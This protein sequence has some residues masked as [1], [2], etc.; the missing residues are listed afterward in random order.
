MIETCIYAIIYFMNVKTFSLGLMQT[1]CYL[2][3]EGKTCVVIDPGVPRKQLR[4]VCDYI[5]QNSLSLA[6]I[7]LTHGHFDHILGVNA[8]CEDFDCAVYVHAADA[9]M[10][11]D[12][13]RNLSGRTLP[14]PYR[15]EQSPSLLRDGQV[16]TFGDIELTVLHT[17][18]H[19]P[20]SCCLLAGDALFC[21]DTLF[22]GSVGRTDL[23]G[24]DMNTLRESLQKLRNLCGQRPLTAYPGHGPATALPDEFYTNPYYQ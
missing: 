1:G 19:T 5:G 18:G 10:L 8:L 6:A 12:P 20:G 3:W 9:G 24:G 4:P 13:E 15:V 22:A 14:N 16:L 7:L 2:L 23:P 17:P 21:G 11:R